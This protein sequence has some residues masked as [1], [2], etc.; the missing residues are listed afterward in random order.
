MAIPKSEAGKLT[1]AQMADVNIAETAIDRAIRENLPL[2]FSVNG[3]RL[4]GRVLTIIRQ[5]YEAVGWAV[6]YI[7]DQREGDYIKL[8]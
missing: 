1:D 5:K 8:S 3:L 6:T 2:T 7:Y 4:R